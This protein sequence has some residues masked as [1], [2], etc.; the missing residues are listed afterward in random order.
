MPTDAPGEE[1]ETMD[2][3]AVGDWVPEGYMCQK[4]EELIHRCQIL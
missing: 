3:F 1:E 4:T 2:G